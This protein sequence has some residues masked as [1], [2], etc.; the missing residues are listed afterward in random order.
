MLIG[1]KTAVSI[2]EWGVDKLGLE[3]KWMRKKREERN[4]LFQTSKNL[5]ALQ[6]KQAKV[7]DHEKE[8]NKQ[9][10]ALICGSKELLGA[11]IDKRYREYISLDGI[12]ESEV[13]E[14]DDIFNAYKNLKGN[15]SR[16]TKYNYVKNHLT[17]IPVE[18]KLLLKDSE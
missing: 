14:F 3:T 13:D 15:H 5:A 9:M 8:W 11:E 1:I 17:V 12:P 4:L 6:E 7:S 10:E 2:F 18:T 16:D